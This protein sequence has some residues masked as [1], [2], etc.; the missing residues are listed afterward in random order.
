MPMPRQRWP[1][2]AEEARRESLGLAAEG[3]A[4]LEQQYKALEAFD[5]HAG[6]YLPAEHR[7]TIERALRHAA[8]VQTHLTRIQLRL[9]QARNGTDGA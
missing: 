3:A 1:N 9:E 7:A 4:E 6:P 2:G 5:R 8:R